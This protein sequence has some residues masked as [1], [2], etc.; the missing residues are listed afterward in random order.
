MSKTNRKSASGRVSNTP[1]HTSYTFLTLILP[2]LRLF[3]DH[4]WHPTD[5]L[6]T[7]QNQPPQPLKVHPRSKNSPKAPLISDLTQTSVHIFRKAVCTEQ[8]EIWYG[9]IMECSSNLLPL[10]TQILEVH[11]SRVLLSTLTPARA[12]ISEH[13]CIRPTCKRSRCDFSPLPEVSGNYTSTRKG[14]RQARPPRKRILSSFLQ[15][16]QGRSCFKFIPTVLLK[17]TKP[18]STQA[19]LVDVH[20][21]RTGKLSVNTLHR[22][23]DTE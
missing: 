18:K 4:H 16:Q 9:H 12:A 3:P 23:R 14:S 6:K 1:N 13:L 7:K 20:T 8:N 11:F 5:T 19:G 22:A 17:M 15:S 21:R 2:N 10:S